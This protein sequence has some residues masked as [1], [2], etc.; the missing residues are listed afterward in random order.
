EV[1]RE[2]EC[3]LVVEAI[4]GGVV[5]GCQPDEQVLRLDR[6]EP[7]QQLLEP[8]SRILRRATAARREIGEL[9]PSGAGVHAA[10]RREPKEGSSSR[11]RR[12]RRAPPPSGERRSLAVP[13]RLVL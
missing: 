13:P 12:R 9:D 4:D 1:E 10:Q 2:D 3:S 11:S 8:R 5:G 6:D 7:G